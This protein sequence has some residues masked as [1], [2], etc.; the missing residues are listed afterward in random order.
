MRRQPDGCGG[1]GGQGKYLE[2]N[3][4]GTRLRATVA[5]EEGRWRNNAQC[6]YHIFVESSSRK[7]SILHY[8]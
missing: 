6:H 7:G 8:I 3:A 1:Q 4:Q 2:S 5:V